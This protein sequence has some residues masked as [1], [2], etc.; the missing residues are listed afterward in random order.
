MSVKIT[1]EEKVMENIMDDVF[2]DDRTV[3]IETKNDQMND[4]KL[5]ELKKRLA[6]KEKPVNKRDR[7]INFGILG[8]GQCGSKLAEQCYKLGYDGLAINT[9]QQDLKHIEMPETNK[10]LL[11]YTVGGAAKS[12]EL[13]EAAARA[14]A[15]KI[16]ALVN[17]HLA[18]AE[19]YLILTSGGG[20]SGAGSFE[21]IVDLL[22]PSGKPVLAVVVLP[23]SNEDGLTKNNS[24]ETLYKLTN[25]I[26]S[27]KI[28]NAV[29]VDNARVEAIYHNVGVMDFFN[30]ANEAIVAPIDAFNRLSM[31]SS[32]VKALDSVEFTKLLLE[33]GL[34]VYGEM[35]VSD[36]KSETAIAECVI[37]NL[38]N[39][40]LADGFDIK[41]CKY[42]GYMVCANKEVWKE[43]PA[44]SLNYAN[45]LI[46]EQCQSPL[47]VFRGIYE[48]N[49]PENIVRIYSLFSGLGLPSSRVEQLKKESASLVQA[50]KEKDVQRSTN[51][52][53]KLDRND[54]TNELQKIKDKVAASKSTFSNFINKNVIDRRG[55]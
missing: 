49:E 38:S 46:T 44:V 17:S 55:K 1:T 29:V 22:S 19:A 3:A 32:A 53:M 42:A 41:Q 34:S 51:L 40:L 52:D 2:K 7:S 45:A 4:D 21:T 6:N 5:T 15:D 27:G 39:N 9:A 33:P 54:T 50:A 48:T 8:L 16:S 13:G 24:V 28:A 18:N 31:E 23:M 25:M 20:G 14:N 37:S 10:L 12:L 35:T 36:Y 47:G 26:K 43:I 30:V 11:E